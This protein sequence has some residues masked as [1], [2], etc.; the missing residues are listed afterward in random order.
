LSNL[1]TN[2]PYYIMYYIDDQ[3]KWSVHTHI[4]IHIMSRKSYDNL[5]HV[6]M[7]LH[8]KA[9]NCI[10]FNFFGFIADAFPT[11][12]GIQMWVPNIKQRRNKESRHTPWFA[13]LWRGRGACWSFGMGLGRVDKLYYSHKPAQ[14]Q[15]KV[16]SA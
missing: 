6:S 1:F 12:W 5:F 11:P 10:I 15:H 8:M 4:Q 13:T 7:F 16:V 3:T 14:N 2:A 9:F